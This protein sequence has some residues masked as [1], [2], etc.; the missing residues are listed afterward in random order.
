M[1]KFKSKPVVIEAWQWNGENAT[2][3][4]KWLY[5][6]EHN[7]EV[8]SLHA[9]NLLIP[10]LEGRVRVSVGDWVIRGTEGELYPCK[11]SVFKTKYEPVDGDNAPD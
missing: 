6:W 2:Q 3:W 11:D 4:P 10:T 8:C 9:G 5:D 1:A 7:N